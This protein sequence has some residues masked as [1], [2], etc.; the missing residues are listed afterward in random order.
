MQSCLP[1]LFCILRY[2]NLDCTEMD[3]LIQWGLTT[4]D[5]AVLRHCLGMIL[6]LSEKSPERAAALLKPCLADPSAIENDSLASVCLLRLC[7]ALYTT[8][9]DPQYLQ[10]LCRFTSGSAES[11]SLQAMELL[12]QLP[13]DVLS[14]LNAAGA[15][16]DGGSDG[17]GDGRQSCWRA[18]PRVWRP[19]ARRTSPT[20]TRWA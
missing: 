1:E 13:Y 5:P 8:S 16:G 12:S 18:S 11:S 20:T 17:R 6:S 3:S 19:A 7:F 9:K 2:C 15:A 10:T 14:H 4:G